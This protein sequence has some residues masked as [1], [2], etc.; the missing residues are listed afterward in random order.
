MIQ[1][2]AY[3]HLLKKYINQTKIT[4]IQTKKHST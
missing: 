2:T 4:L 1:N 3:Q